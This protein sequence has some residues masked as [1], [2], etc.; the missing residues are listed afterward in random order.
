MQININPPL[1]IT[2]IQVVFLLVIIVTILFTVIGLT[3]SILQK[4]IKPS[5][6][7]YF[8]VQIDCTKFL[9]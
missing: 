3:T 6:N 7:S 4:T 1:M 2:Q 8:Y 5:R 9:I